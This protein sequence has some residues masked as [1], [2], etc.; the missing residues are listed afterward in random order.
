MPSNKDKFY[1]NCM[2]SGTFSQFDPVGI[3]CD[4]W[5]HSKMELQ[6]N[7]LYRSV[8]IYLVEEGSYNIESS[9]NFTLTNEQLLIEGNENRLELK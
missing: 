5:N 9:I 4:P 1:N 6:I 3:W 2:F 8:Q 7:K